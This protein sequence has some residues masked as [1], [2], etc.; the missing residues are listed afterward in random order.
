MRSQVCE[1]FLDACLQNNIKEVLHIYEC[2]IKVI[3]D[4]KDLN[5]LTS[6]DLSI[7][8]DNI[9]LLL[10]AFGLVANKNKSWNGYILIS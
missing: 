10:Q 7:I 1:G 6:L 2:Y 4:G 3:I 5:Y 9:D 8:N